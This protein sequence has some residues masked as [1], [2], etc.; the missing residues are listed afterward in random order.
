MIWKLVA[1]F[2]GSRWRAFCGFS[3]E[4]FSGIA[5]AALD[6]LGYEYSIQEIE[7]TQG[8]QTM[9]G[10]DETGRRVSVTDPVP[11]DVDVITATVD[12]VTKIMLSF[13]VTKERRKEATGGLCVVTISDITDETRLS[14]ARFMT[15]V[16]AMS[17][18]PPWKLTHHIGFR[19]AVLLRLKVRVLWTYWNRVAETETESGG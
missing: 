14:I 6:E 5:S 12:P 19:L 4:D 11:F 9:L 7:T 18:R 10:A 3:P 13:F 15:R 2:V 17:D 16:M 1:V 8:E